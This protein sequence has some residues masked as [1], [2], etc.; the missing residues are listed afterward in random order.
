MKFIDP[1]GKDIVILMNKKEF[2]YLINSQGQNTLIPKGCY[3]ERI[4]NG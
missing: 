2:T 1:D 4:V 3:I